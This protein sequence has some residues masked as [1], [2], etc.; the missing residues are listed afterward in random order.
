MSGRL[1]RETQARILLGRAIRERMAAGIGV[2]CIAPV[3][4]DLFVSAVEEERQQAIQLCQ[5]CPILVECRAAAIARR[6]ASPYIYGGQIWWPSR[7]T[8]DGGA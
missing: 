3:T 8:E 1:H 4:S 6:E 7:W 5:R 2:A